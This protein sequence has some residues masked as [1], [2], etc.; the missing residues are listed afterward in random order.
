MR[1]SLTCHFW[2]I[3]PT[4]P[5]G[6]R[7]T[8]PAEQAP[9]RPSSNFDCPLL[10]VKLLLHHTQLP[11]PFS[12]FRP[13]Q[14]RQP[15]RILAIGACE[16]E[17]FDYWMSMHS[18]TSKSCRGQQKNSS[19]IGMDASTTVTAHLLASV[20]PSFPLAVSF[21]SYLLFS[22]LNSFHKGFDYLGFRKPGAPHQPESRA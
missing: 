5:Y 12:V 13:R 4:L 9:P 11:A 6:P 10:K 8:T 1:L 3:Q 20:R 17:S 19:N 14:L 2:H 22:L 18:I 7:P 16:Q 15:R 21:C